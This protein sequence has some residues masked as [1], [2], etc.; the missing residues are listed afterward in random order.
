MTDRAEMKVDS[1][2]KQREGSAFDSMDLLEEFSGVIGIPP[3]TAEKEETRESISFSDPY[4]DLIKPAG[5]A[6]SFS[7]QSPQ[8]EQIAW[9]LGDL[10]KDKNRDV[11]TSDEIKEAGRSPEAWNRF[12][13]MAGVYSSNGELWISPIQGTGGD[14]G[15]IFPFPKCDPVDSDKENAAYHFNKAYLDNTRFNVPGISYGGMSSGQLTDARYRLSAEERGILW[16]KRTE[17]E[18]EQVSAR[19]AIQW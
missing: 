4:V 10:F 15:D 9:S 16:D 7:P 18:L 2:A 11:C 1:A 17:I 13:K 14:Y 12:A 19:K 6:S 5:D 8:N 3:K